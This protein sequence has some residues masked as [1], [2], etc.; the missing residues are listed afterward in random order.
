VPWAHDG[1]KL[2]PLMARDGPKLGLPMG[3][4]GPKLGAPRGPMM[5]PSL[6]PMGHGGPSLGPTWAHDGAQRENAMC[7]YGFRI[8]DLKT[9]CVCMVLAS[10][11]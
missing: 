11:M 1:P 9:L 5:G 4:D 8:I 6:G 2:G 3:H 10:S 7:L